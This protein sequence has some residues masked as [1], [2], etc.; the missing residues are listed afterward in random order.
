MHPGPKRL[1]SPDRVC[2]LPPFGNLN[3]VCLDHYFAR[4]I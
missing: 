3:A 2:G 4:H 1:L